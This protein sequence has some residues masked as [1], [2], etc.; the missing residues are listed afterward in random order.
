MGKETEGQKVRTKP[1]EEIEENVLDF[2]EHESVLTQSEKYTN[3]KHE[4]KEKCGKSEYSQM[5]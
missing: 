2:K 5:L 4:E 3:I 1:A